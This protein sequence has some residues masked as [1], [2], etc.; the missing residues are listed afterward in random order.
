MGLFGSLLQAVLDNFQNEGSE[1]SSLAQA[2]LRRIENNDEGGLAG[3]LEQLK[4]K[5]LGDIV[6]SWVGTGPNKPITPQQIGQGLGPD[7]LRQLAASAGVSTETVS[8]HLS[9]ILPKIVDRL[10][11]DGRLP[12]ADAGSGPSIPAASEAVEAGK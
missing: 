10:T 12:T 4:S 8:Q 9:E 7:W 3:L 5:G 6:Q 11:P 2:V 1:H